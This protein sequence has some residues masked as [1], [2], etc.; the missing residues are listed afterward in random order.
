M[1]DTSEP[2]SPVHALSRGIVP[3]ITVGTIAGLDNIA[4]GLA[5]ASLLFAGSLASGLSI[6][7]VVVFLGGGILALTV[8]LKSRMPTTIAMVQETTVAILAAALAAHVATLAAPP[9]VKV[10]TALTVLGGASIVTGALFWLT[11]RLR[12]GALARFLPFPVVAGFLAGSGWLL[13]AGGMTMATGETGILAFAAALSHADILYRVVPAV[14]FAVVMLVALNR[15]P[16]PATVPA[17]MLVATLLFYAVLA[18]IGMDVETARAHGHLPI[19][20]AA[21]DVVWP[22]PDHLTQID[23]NAVLATLPS[24]LSVAALS[25]VGLLLNVSGLELATGRDIDSN[26]ELRATGVGNVLSGAFGGPSGY[27]G[28]TMTLLSEKMGVRDRGAGIASAVVM[29]VGLFLAQS[30]IS[31]IPVFLTA[32]FIFYLGLE[33]LKT[34]VVDTRRQLPLIEWGIVIAILAAVATIGFLEGMAAGLL[35]SI[36]VFVFNYSRLPVVR[37]TTTG[38]EHRSTVDRSPAAMDFLSSNGDTVE[39]VQLQGYLFFGT[40]D[41]MVEH[42]R[43]RL[44]ATKRVALRFLVLDFR[45]VSGVDSAATT[46]FNKIR[47][48]TDPA[49]VR[50]F[51]TH[52]SPEVEQA[53]RR[54]GIDFS[55]DCL[56]NL[57]TDIDHALE[58]VEET[59]LRERPELDAGR[60]LLNH[61]TAAIGPHPRLR[62]FIAA[63]SQLS[64]EPGDVLIK[65]GEDADDVFFVADGRVRV[66]LTLPNGRVLRL[67]RM[68]GGAIVGEIALYRHQKRTADV[69]VE[70]PSEIFRLSADDL[71]RL[72]REDSELAILAHR[73]L[74]M[75]LA[76]KLSVSN[77][78]IQHLHR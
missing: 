78:M 63:M 34:W 50:V 28:L 65:A 16:S 36:A 49:G 73:L 13:V 9:E 56:M 21:G 47:S 25:M 45:H 3:A 55:E 44:A 46:C 26:A 27:V 1:A 68:T 64:L 4:T 37:M 35:V 5:I 54:G 15:Y 67:R 20:A 43:R 11:G 24:I 7:V 61:L 18:A 70:M 38:A 42:V 53:L 60:G 19:L 74:A 40:A 69:I 39:V 8:A 51:F 48:L 75:N 22:T 32:G 59:L 66:Q 57:E 30:L 58:R 77:R 14:L 71:A 72:E 10:I 17:V 31:R 12:F 2:Q 6:G 23:W 52:L 41:R 76:E 29:F 33:M 62:D